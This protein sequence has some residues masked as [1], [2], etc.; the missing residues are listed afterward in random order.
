MKKTLLAG[1]LLAGSTLFGADFSIGIGIGAPYGYYPP[2]PPRVAYVPV[3]PGPYYEWVDGY[4]YPVGRGW[5]WRAGYWA[6]PPYA[7]AYWVR[8]RY[9]GGRYYEGR[10]DRRG[11]DRDERDRH[12]RGRDRDFRYDYRR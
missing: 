5:E 6:A 12:E 11:Y 7:G 3:R 9:E 8:P 2:P 1:L 4:Y 10:W